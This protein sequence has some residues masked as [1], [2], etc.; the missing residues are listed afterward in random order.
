MSVGGKLFGQETVRGHF[1]YNS[2]VLDSIGEF[3]M[4]VFEKSINL[5]NFMSV[6][7][8]FVDIINSRAKGKI[9]LNKLL[10]LFIA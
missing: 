5:L 2:L 9:Y 8:W 6:C 1:F 7:G 10:C 4:P 3:E